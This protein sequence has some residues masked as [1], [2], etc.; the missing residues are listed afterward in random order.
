MEAEKSHDLLSA[1][2]SVVKFSLSCRVWEWGMWGDSCIILSWVWKPES[3]ELLRMRAREGWCPSSS[4]RANSSFLCLVCSIW[5][6]NGL[7]DAHPHW[8]G[9]A[10]WHCLLSQMLIPLET[11]TET[12]PEITFYQQSGHPLAQSGRHIKFTI[13]SAKS[14]WDESCKIL[15]IERQ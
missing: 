1:G 4:D 13:T 15:D 3:Q 14:S 12:H 5:T 7:D 11:P 10:P 8:G 2:K 9:W 6:L